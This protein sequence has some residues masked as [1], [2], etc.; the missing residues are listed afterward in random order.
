MY[1]T[2][3][4][5]IDL[6]RKVVDRFPSGEIQM[7]YWSRFGTKAMAKNNTV[8]RASGSELGWSVDGPE[9]I[10]TAVPRTRL[11]KAISVFEAETV[12]RLTTG[13]QR[14]ARTA[15]RT[16]VLRKIVQYHRYAF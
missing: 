16:P 11:L 12:D 6:L 14:F 4:D 7:D 13:Y 8:V 1:L 9:D 2:K 10:L 5:G 3:S 15:A